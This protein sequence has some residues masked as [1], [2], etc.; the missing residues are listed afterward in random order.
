MAMPADNRKVVLLKSLATN[1]RF[2]ALVPPDSGL[3]NAD[4]IE[5]FPKDMLLGIAY[6]C[7]E[8]GLNDFAIIRSTYDTLDQFPDDEELR[9]ELMEIIADARGKLTRR[10][11]ELWRCIS[12]GQAHFLGTELEEF[13]DYVVKLMTRGVPRKTLDT[14]MKLDVF[15]MVATTEALLKGEFNSDYQYYYGPLLETTQEQLQELP[16]RAFVAAIFHDVLLAILD[17]GNYADRHIFDSRVFQKFIALMF[18]N[19]ATTDPVFYGTNKADYGVSADKEMDSTPLYIA[20]AKA[21]RALEGEWAP[22]PQPGGDGQA[23]TDRLA[24]TVTRTVELSNLPIAD[25]QVLE[26]MRPICE[27]AR[28]LLHND[29]ARARECGELILR[30]THR[31]FTQLQ[32]MG[33]FSPATDSPVAPDYR[34]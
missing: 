28:L 29:N 24:A 12:A 34:E 14:T 8:D 10:L 16:A 30:S 32:E 2:Y 13:K 18:V 27:T 17:E 4:T 26:R 22:E 20:I 19:Y 1:N 33:I 11:E 9:V 6:P 15:E 31:L 7:L 3:R 23:R 5:A 21:L 25:Q